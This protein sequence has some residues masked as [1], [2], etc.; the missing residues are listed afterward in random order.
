MEHG[1]EGIAAFLSEHTIQR[2]LNVAKVQTSNQAAGAEQTA[3]LIPTQ[4]EASI[5]MALQRGK[6]QRGLSEFEVSESEVRRILLIIFGFSNAV[7]FEN[8]VCM[9]IFVAPCIHR[10]GSPPVGKRLCLMDIC[11]CKSDCQV[12]SCK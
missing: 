2:Q 9:C 7:P 10:H 8:C 5:Q 3:Q 6:R 4:K 1:H 12:I 11:V